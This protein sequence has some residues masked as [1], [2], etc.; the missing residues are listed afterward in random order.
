MDERPIHLDLEVARRAR[1]FNL[2][3]ADVLQLKQPAK[4]QTVLPGALA[5]DQLDG[6]LA[7]LAISS[8]SAVLDLLSIALK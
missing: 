5:L 4:L 3:K 2:R 7:V 6:S 1:V 8:A